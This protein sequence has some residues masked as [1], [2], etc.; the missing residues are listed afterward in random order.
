[1]LRGLIGDGPMHGGFDVSLVSERLAST[2]THG[3]GFP[4]LFRALLRSLATGRPASR[5][6]LARDLG[7]PGGR[8][9]AALGQAQ[10]VEYDDMGNVTGY[11]LTLNP[12]PHHFEVNGHCLYTWC[13]LDTL[14]FPA[15][16]GTTARIRSSCPVTRAPVSLTVSPHAVHGLAPSEAMLSLVQPVRADDIRSAFCC[17]VHFLASRSAATQWESTHPGSIVL[18]IHDAWCLGQD[19]AQ[20]L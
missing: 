7:W 12:T 5:E 17:H 8:V 3:A 11:G 9:A 1:M 20:R 10:G 4:A 19:L 16:L 15:L 13:A 6:S 14:V 18:S 2:A